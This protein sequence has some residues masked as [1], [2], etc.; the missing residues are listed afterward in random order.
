[1]NLLEPERKYLSP[2]GDG[3]TGTSDP[4]SGGF[5]PSLD[6]EKPLDGHSV[7]GGSF[8]NNQ[9]KSLQGELTEV[10]FAFSSINDTLKGLEHTVQKHSSVI[11]DLGE[12]RNAVP[13][14]S[15]GSFHASFMSLR[16]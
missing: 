1:M 8:N 15:S 2:T 13:L 10:I 5:G 3:S 12:L 6:A 9:L 11:T 4:G 14:L 7:I 16:L